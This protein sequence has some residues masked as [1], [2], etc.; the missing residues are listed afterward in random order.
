MIS[1][2]VVNFDG[3]LGF[4]TLFGDHGRGGNLVWRKEEPNLKRKRRGKEGKHR[5]EIN[6]FWGK[7]KLKSANEVGVSD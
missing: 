3:G 6:K 4:F 5:E 1:V 7:K 2:V